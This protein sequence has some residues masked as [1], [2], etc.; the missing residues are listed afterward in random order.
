MKV[1]QSRHLTIEDIY[2]KRLM[3]MPG[4]RRIEIASEL[5]ELTRELSRQGIRNRNP[6]LTKEQVDKELWKTIYKE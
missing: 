5:S 1:K 2:L 3:N 6:H 4:Q